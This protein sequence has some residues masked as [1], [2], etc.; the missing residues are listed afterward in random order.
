MGPLGHDLVGQH[1]LVV[2]A[3][4]DRDPALTLERRHQGLGRLHVLPAVDRQRARRPARPRALG[5]A[6][7]HQRTDSG[8]GHASDE[9][10]PDCPAPLAAHVLLASSL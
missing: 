1:V 6:G 5:A 2:R 8:D 4:A 9:G 3:Q 10:A 7:E